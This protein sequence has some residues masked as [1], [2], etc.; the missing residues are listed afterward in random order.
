MTGSDGSNELHHMC[1]NNCK[2]HIDDECKCRINAQ[3]IDVEPHST[4][5]RI[6]KCALQSVNICTW[7]HAQ[8]SIIHLSAS[9]TLLGS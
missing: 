7:S 2:F 8:L 6:P 4:S 1:Y 3:R 5:I 9:N